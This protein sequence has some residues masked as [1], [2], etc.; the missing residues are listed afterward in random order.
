MGETYASLRKCM[1]SKGSS[2]PEHPVSKAISEYVYNKP[3][4][5]R[6]YI[7]ASN[8]MLTQALGVILVFDYLFT[9]Q[10]FIERLLYT[11][12]H[13]MCQVT[14]FRFVHFCGWQKV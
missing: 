12:H 10:T 4:K 1:N 6:N 14:E 13:V 8:N 11:R 2:S 7:Y 9:K 5:D 3:K